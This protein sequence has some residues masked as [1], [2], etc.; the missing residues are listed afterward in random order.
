[1]G[2]TTQNLA[3]S[4]LTFSVLSFLLLIVL[5]V[6]YY[7]PGFSSSFQGVGSAGY[8]SGF[9]SMVTLLAAFSPDISLLSGFV[10]DIINGA[11]R[12]SVTSLFGILAVVLHWMVGRLLG[13]KAPEVSASS[14]SAVTQLLGVGS[15]PVNTILNAINPTA[16][17]APPAPSSAPSSGSGSNPTSVRVRFGS[18]VRRPGPGSISTAPDLETAAVPTSGKG[19]RSLKGLGPINPGARLS[20]AAT[21]K[22]GGLPANFNPCVIRGLGMFD[23]SNSPMGM[24]ALSSVWII[25]LLDMSVESKRTGLEI[26]MYLLFSALVYGLNIYSYKELQCGYGA[27]MSEAAKSTMFPI[28]VGL[29]TGASGYAILHS[30]AP[31][32]LPLD[33]QRIGSPAAP[34]RNATCAPPNDNDQFVCDAYKDGKRISTAVV[35]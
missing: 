11:F 14:A 22:G 12:Y 16:P 29:V 13:Y 33:S 15:N 6:S 27:T 2:D 30:S 5:L 3:A 18:N 4:A 9:K 34:G 31:A 23:L 24:A 32:Y 28:F 35:A 26:G 10:S 8:L 21:L 20:R 25:Y 1:M 7:F 17:S 19:S